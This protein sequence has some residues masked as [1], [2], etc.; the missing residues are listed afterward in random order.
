MEN[1]RRVQPGT[2]LRSRIDLIFR[3]ILGRSTQKT[4]KSSAEL[5]FLDDNSEA[6]F[7]SHP[8]K[9]AMTPIWRPCTTMKGSAILVLAYLCKY[10]S[11]LSTAGHYRGL[12]SPELSSPVPSEQPFVVSEIV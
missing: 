10:N 9:D 5:S 7:D 8:P 3:T 2:L 4:E 11:H 6:S 1:R 12:A